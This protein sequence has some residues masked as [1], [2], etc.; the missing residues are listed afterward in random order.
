MKKT[1]DK[2]K[3][4]VNVEEIQISGIE[5]A[6]YNP[7]KISEV[8]ANK[9]KQSIQKLGFVIPVIYNKSN[10]VLLAGHQRVKAAKKLGYEK[11]PAIGLDIKKYDDEV[12]FNILHNTLDNSQQSATRRNLINKLIKDY[13]NVFFAIETEDSEIVYGDDYARVTGYD[14]Y[15]RHVIQEEDKHFFEEQYGKYD[16]SSFGGND[17]NQHRAQMSR[18]ERM[19]SQLY[20]R[21]VENYATQNPDSVILDFGSGK[22][23]EANRLKSKGYDVKQLEFYHKKGQT[24]TD[25]QQE[26]VLSCS[27][28]YDAI[29]IDSVLNSVTDKKYQQA[30]IRL[31]NA[32]IKKGGHFFLSSRSASFHYK[33]LASNKK[34]DG[35]ALNKVYS[36]DEDSF[37]VTFKGGLPFFQKFDYS[38]EIIEL[39]ENNGFELI[40]KFEHT[41]FYLE[42]IK[43]SECEGQ[44]EAIKTEFSLPKS[45]GS[46]YNPIKAIQWFEKVSDEDARTGKDTQDKTS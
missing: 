44:T 38:N 43:V 40:N 34:D 15:N 13:G 41:S 21:Y 10:M 46:R 28:R 29:V 19:R 24:V 8:K 27:S 2:S 12:N 25:Q 37:S 3:E 5:L 36:T 23:F 22:G 14:W 1:A 26:E 18:G 33:R 31:A 42:F 45:D 4:L 6:T 30:L 9:L 35:K 11:V 32:F 39:C 16:Y 17:F 20:T 7:R